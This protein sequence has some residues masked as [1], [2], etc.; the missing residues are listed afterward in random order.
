MIK[1]L[2]KKMLAIDRYAGCFDILDSSGTWHSTLVV[3]WWTKSHLQS[4]GR[5]LNA[6]VLLIKTCGTSLKGNLY[7]EIRLI[8]WK[9]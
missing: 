5:S 6:Q 4:P 8:G 1:M 9:D 3:V 2:G 7:S